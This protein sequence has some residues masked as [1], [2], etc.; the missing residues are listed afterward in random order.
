MPIKSTPVE[1]WVIMTGE[2][3]QPGIDGELMRGSRPWCPV[4]MSA[5]GMLK[6]YDRFF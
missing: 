1:Y 5:M 2:S 6:V 3:S 4:R